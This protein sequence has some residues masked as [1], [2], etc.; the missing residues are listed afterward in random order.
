[1]FHDTSRPWEIEIALDELAS[2]VLSPC[3]KLDHAGEGWTMRRGN[4][5]RR[6]WLRAS[7]AL[8]AATLLGFTA[9]GCQSGGIWDDIKNRDFR[10]RDLVNNQDP[11]TVLETDSN[12]DARARAMRKLKEPLQNGGSQE[13]QD[14][15]MRMLTEGA[16]TDNRAVCRLAAVDALKRMRDPRATPALIQAYYNATSFQLAVANTIRVEAVTALGTKNAPDAVALLVRAA[17]DPGIEAN[18]PVQPAAFLRDKN[19]PSPDSDVD[20][21]LARDIRLA[22]IRSLAEIRSPMATAALIP[23]LDEK[24]VAIRDRAYE[25][26]VAITGKK[27]MPAE[28]KAWEEALKK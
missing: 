11:L 15:V 16:T 20:K 22:A 10:F 27:D 17:T 7:L 23:L 8:G 18:A 1:M 26:L 4:S 25:A 6:K 2:L 24:D 14:K 9:A 12:G 13:Q 21:A 28:P 5:G 19:K 3:R